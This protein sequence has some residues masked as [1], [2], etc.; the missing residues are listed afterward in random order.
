[1]VGSGEEKRQKFQ[2]VALPAVP[3]YILFRKVTLFETFY[4]QIIRGSAVTEF[5]GHFV[6]IEE[7]MLS[8]TMILKYPLKNFE[9][10][11]ELTLNI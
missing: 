6:A 7:N 3:P 1:M 10:P 5:L 8:N 2:L 9:L 11:S 4:I